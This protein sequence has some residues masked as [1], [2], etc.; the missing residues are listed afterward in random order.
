MSSCLVWASLCLV[1]RGIPVLSDIGRALSQV[2]AHNT[3]TQ[4][5]FVGQRAHDV[6]PPGAP[7]GT[8]RNCRPPASLPGVTATPAHSPDQA[9]LFPLLMGGPQQMP[10]MAHRPARSLM[11]IPA[12]AAM[13]LWEAGLPGRAR[14]PWGVPT[15]GWT[16]VAAAEMASELG[17]GPGMPAVTS[18]FSGLRPIGDPRANRTARTP[19][20]GS[21]SPRHL[22]FCLRLTVPEAVL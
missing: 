14:G 3:A 13:A 11:P 16:A 4:N 18:H 17:C 8:D 21:W 1:L 20:A 2:L 12:A 15:W 19:A 22:L 9:R 6:T 7:C 5:S 10:L